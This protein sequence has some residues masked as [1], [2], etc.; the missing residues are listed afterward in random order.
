MMSK[1]KRQ[2][3][4]EHETT[5]QVKTQID[6]LSYYG[7]WS[8]ILG[9][10]LAVMVLVVGA[11]VYNNYSASS[12]NQSGGVSAGNIGNVTIINNETASGTKDAL[13]VIQAQNTE[14]QTQMEAL[15]KQTETEELIA[16]LKDKY[17]YGFQVFGIGSNFNIFPSQAF[18][19]DYMIDWGSAKVEQITSERIELRLPDYFGK[20]N[21][22]KFTNLH[23]GL[24]LKKGASCSP[25]NVFGVIV[26]VEVVNVKDGRV[27]CVIGF[28]KSQDL[29]DSKP[30]K[31]TENAN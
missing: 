13:A 12:S 24:S 20:K 1:N 11:A 21:G 25:Y 29:P 23:V 6:R 28:K 31:A 8:S 27:V 3:L 7:N 26:A 9:L 14:I 2:Q 19:E 4:S 16:Q 10:L 15:I 5:I 22:N 18:S 17:Q 30:L